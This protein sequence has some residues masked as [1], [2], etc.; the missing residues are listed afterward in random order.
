MADFEDILKAVA[1][2]E[3]TSRGISR[4]CE[5]YQTYRTAKRRRGP[6]ERPWRE[7]D[8][9]LA[10]R[11]LSHQDAAVRFVAAE[12][13]GPMQH[14]SQDQL[15]PLIEATRREVHPG[16]VKSFVKRLGPST[17]RNAEVRELMMV[18]GGHLDE[19]VRLEVGNWLTAAQ[20]LGT[21]GLLERAM[22]MVR[23]DPS[24]RV[25]LRVLDDLGDSGDER[26]L[27]FLETFLS[28][29]QK[30]AR[31]HASAVRALINMWSSPIPKTTPSRAAYRRTLKLLKATPR[32]D[33]SPP[34]AAI[35]GLRWVTEPRFLARAEWFDRA[36]LIGALEALI[37]DVQAGPKARKAAVELLIRYQ[38]PPARF[39]SLLKRC[40]AQK[41][42]LE[43]SR[44]VMELLRSALD[45][46]A[47]KLPSP[48]TQG[49]PK[50][51]KLPPMPKLPPLK[52]P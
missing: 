22:R 14:A 27:P 41:G 28:D 31:A 2:C 5:P 44:A 17:Y 25:R 34:W 23:E 29:A 47:T 4:E 16:V 15:K 26:V 43:A 10:T 38:E 19:R 7:V 45:P 51:I 35:G 48:G 21:P 11:L 40:E 46:E 52:A 8:R 24:E 3:I 33:D 36:A 18:L 49:P 39:A 6:I 30:S 32:H 12:L 13:M 42:D 20:G 50:G 9:E 1:P 37:V